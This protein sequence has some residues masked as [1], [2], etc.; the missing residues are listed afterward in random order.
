MHGGWLSH[1]EINTEGT[2]ASC[3]VSPAR[4]WARFISITLNWRIARAAASLA[5]RNHS[6]GLDGKR[7]PLLYRAGKELA[8]RLGFEIKCTWTTALSDI[9]LDRPEASR[10]Y[11][12]ASGHCRSHWSRKNP[13]RGNDLRIHAGSGPTGFILRHADQP[14]VSI[15]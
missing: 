14:L 2:T 8:L 9:D 5:N 12:R 3:Y 6:L 4:S 7:G 10:T 1:L 11:P 13:G 15:Q